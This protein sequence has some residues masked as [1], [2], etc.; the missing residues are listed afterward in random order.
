[1]QIM[2]RTSATTV[3]ALHFLGGSAREWEAVAER[4]P[5]NLRLMAL[6]LPGFGDAA[7]S[8]GHDVAAMADHVAGQIRAQAPRRWMLAGHSM[9]AKVAAAIARRAEDGAPGL[10]GLAGLVTLAG[11]PPSPEPMAEERR[12]RMLGWFAG[13][14]EQSR[15]EAEGFIDANTASR[16]PDPLRELAVEDVLRADRAAWMAWLERGSREDWSRRIGLLNTPAL[17]LAGEADSDLGPDAQ[18]RLMAPYFS[19]AKLATVPGA[20][21]LLPLEAPDAVAELI[22]G[23]ARRA[24]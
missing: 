24:G 14:A 21:H 6:D 16:L 7:G 3:F 2:D 22:G 4:L 19:A 11:S 17:V 12:R 8:G 20:A 13:P 15:A 1:V 10:S 23:F 18:R 9:G 5:P